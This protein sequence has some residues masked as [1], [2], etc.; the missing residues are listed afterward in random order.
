MAI[1]INYIVKYQ[2][3]YTSSYLFLK[4]FTQLVEKGI[5]VE[6]LLNSNV[7]QFSFDYDEWPGTHTNDG[8][9]I[10]PYNESIF[11]IR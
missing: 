5:E 4:N 11:N 7:F 9:Y 1:I 3:N 2:D 6:T 10:R 8:E